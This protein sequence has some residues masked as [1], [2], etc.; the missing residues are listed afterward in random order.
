MILKDSRSWGLSDLKI[1]LVNPIDNTEDNE[2]LAYSVATETNFDICDIGQLLLLNFRSETKIFSCSGEDYIGG[3]SP[4]FG[5]YGRIE[6]QF[7]V[8]AHNGLRV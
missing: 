6:T 1:S 8:K 3:V 7:L 5:Q 4:N 2:E